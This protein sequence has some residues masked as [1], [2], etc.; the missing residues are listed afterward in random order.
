MTAELVG[1]EGEL[2]RVELFLRSVQDGAR[3][4]VIEGEAGAG[5]TSL[6]NAALAGAAR[7]GLRTLSARPAEAETSFAYAALGD[8]LGEHSEAVVA[9]PPRQR[10]ALEVALLTDESNGE[11]PD[12]HTVALGLLGVLRRLAGEA[13]L[14]LAVD[15][16][17]W[18]DTPSELVLRFAVRRLGA[19][20]VGVVLAWR[21]EGG[22]PPPL[23]LGRALAADR[24]ERLG[25]PPLSLGAVQRLIQDRLGFLP[26]RPA[27]RR[28]H[29]LSGGNPFFAL[30][31]GR[32]LRAGTLELQPG[33]RLPVALEALVDARLGALSAEARRALAAAAAMA[34]PTVE[35][36]EAVSGSGREAL[37][38]AARAQVADVRDGRIRFAH[39]LLASGAYAAMDPSERRELHARAAGHAGDPEERARHLSLA[40]AGPDKAVA[41]ALE[42]AARR[43]EARGAPPAAAEL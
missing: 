39:P 19:A 35:L 31:L 20:P 17:Q 37:D 42:D 43:A 26:P 29:E 11:A 6:W 32:A 16:V 21:T 40:A 13:P 23:E 36:V 33:E 27:L 8:L 2:E 30:E 5:K 38:E 34:Q 22:E 28:L 9:L 41:G 12:Q 14:V 1:R 10:R 18:L 3:A 24:L 25:V 7:G 4:L 15:D